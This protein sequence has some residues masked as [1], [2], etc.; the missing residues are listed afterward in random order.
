MPGFESDVLGLKA[1]DLYEAAKR[2]ENSIMERVP[3]NVGVLSGALES[4]IWI[5]PLRSNFSRPVTSKGRRTAIRI[6]G[7]RFG[8]CFSYPDAAD[9]AHRKRPQSCYNA[10]RFGLV[11]NQE[12][13]RHQSTMA[14]TIGSELG[15][16]EV[17]S[18]LGAGGMGEV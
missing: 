8:D 18:P 6:R 7:C 4:I 11:G 3:S 13:I 14:L 16:Y 10:S 12:P 2:A 9:R 1:K 15:P 5:A 17:L